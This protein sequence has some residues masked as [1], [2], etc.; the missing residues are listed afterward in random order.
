MKIMFLQELT[1]GLLNGLLNRRFKGLFA[2]TPTVA[3]LLLTAVV[4]ACASS[5]DSNSS[6]STSPP[7]TTTPPPMT[8]ADCMFAED[9]GT[10]DCGLLTLPQVFDYPT[11][12]NITVGEVLAGKE[13]NTDKIGVSNFTFTQIINGNI[14]D[15][16]S[17]PSPVSNNNQLMLLASATALNLNIS[18]IANNVFGEF[19]IDL[20]QHN[21]T[22]VKVRYTITITAVND[23]PVFL[24][25]MGSEDQ[26]NEANETAATP[27]NYTFADIPFNST[28]G[29]S[30]GNVSATDIDSDTIT[31][32]I[33]GGTDDTDLFQINP[34]TGE[35]TLKEVAAN[36]MDSEIEYTF[37]VTASDDQGGSARIVIAVSVLPFPR[38]DCIFAEDEGTKDCELFA[39]PQV[40][41]SNT[42]YN[43]TFG[44][45]NKGNTSKIG[46]GNFNFTQIIQGDTLNHP[47]VNFNQTQKQLTLSENAI[48]VNITISG[49]D[50]N[51]FGE[52]YIELVLVDND[53]VAVKA[54]YTIS[55]TPVNDDPVFTA[56][57]DNF[58]DIP[59]NSTA[60]YSVGN[61]SATDID[62]DT[63]TYSIIGGTNVTNL[64]QIS[65]TGE[66][67]TGSARGEI[68]L[69]VMASTA[70]EYSFNVTANDGNG[71]SVMAEI[72]V[73]V[74]PVTV[75]DT[76]PPVFT[77]TPY[78]FDLSLSAATAADVFV[79]NV[80]AEVAEGTNF[81]YSLAGGSDLFKLADDENTDGSINI[82]LSRAAT[83][84]DFAASSITFQVV[85]EHTLGGI[86][87]EE[88]IT[89]NLIND[90][91]LDDDFDGDGVKGFYDASP[92]DATMN[93]TGN[94]EPNDPYNITNIYQLQAIAGVD[95]TGM[96]LGSSSFTN[97]FLYGTDAAEQLTKHY[98]LAND[99][100]AS[101]TADTTVWAKPAVTTYVGHGWTPIAGKDGESFSG[102]FNG[103]GYAINGLTSV[104]RQGA[105]SRH[106]GLF[107]INNGNIIALGLQDI[108]MKIQA[109]NNIYDGTTTTSNIVTAGSHA[110]GLVGLNQGD[111]VISYSYATGLVNASMD[112]IG[113]LVGL[114]QGEISYSY[115]TATVQGEGDTGGLVGTNEPG[116]ILSSYATGDVSGGAGIE[117]R[118]G[119]TGGLAGSISD[120]AAIINT[121]YATGLV[122]GR[123]VTV[124]NLGGIV[125]ERAETVVT[126]VSSYWDNET[127]LQNE[128]VGKGRAVDGG[129]GN[130]TGTTPLT[131]AQLQG[132]GLGGVVISSA[133]PAPDCTGLFPSS[134]WGNDPITTTDGATIA[135]GWSFNAGEYPSLSAFRTSGGTNKQLLPS[136]SD[137]QCHRDN[138]PLGCP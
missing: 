85:A 30:V 60:G 61:V 96:P 75:V 106:F 88:D 45:V 123:T 32:S 2:R 49:I 56:P 63:I 8:T 65:S 115:S 39:L 82:F 137:Q 100:N 72:S 133:L 10:Q 23:A 87:S 124:P 128:G 138:M 83:L 64:F 104:L 44:E 3:V 90:L 95:H 28:A 47:V 102:S 80:E 77:R 76:T 129:T 135:R 134:H 120:E 107:G 98:K 52:F 101:D 31:Y 46:P 108:N 78:N 62:N 59:F 67:A 25:V 33:I 94:G 109:E 12:Y 110:G 66:S 19:Y 105:A 99:I 17:V 92:H 74:L 127:T 125:A 5:S 11:N 7:S 116:V 111:G 37:N 1:G 6:D 29:Y 24:A 71:G 58:A 112:S 26:F 103:E 54:L 38:A 53:E 15:P 18:G 43:I 118:A 121:S 79:Y 89:V 36:L 34:T 41:N 51:V 130:T 126:I 50:D 16:K 113:G 27:A 21:N 122:S 136:L 14:S 55:I 13:V 119:T 81:V 114:N 93:I 117:N 86:S 131:T 48:A 68:T 97:S 91:S 35:I 20:V 73:E 69:K 4:A 9:N 42:T 70:G 84:S 57:P 22:S 132:C 40:F